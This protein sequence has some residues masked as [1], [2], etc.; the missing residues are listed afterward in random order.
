M[1]KEMSTN[2]TSVK[3]C[4]TTKSICYITCDSSSLMFSSTI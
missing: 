3:I 1:E 2:P 4:V